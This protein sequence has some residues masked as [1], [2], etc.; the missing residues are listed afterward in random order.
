LA[1][2]SISVQFIFKKKHFIYIQN[3][4]KLLQTALFC[5]Q[6]TK[7]DI[8]TLSKKALMKLST[9][10]NPKRLLG[11]STLVLTLFAVG[12]ETQETLNPTLEV[13]QTLDGKPTTI[14]GKYIITLHEETLNYRKTND[15]DQ[16]QAGMR[17]VAQDIVAKYGVSST[18]VDRVYGSLLT[19]FSATLSPSQVAALRNDPSVQ[20]V[21]EDG[22]A[23]A[24]ADVKQTSATWGLDRIDQANLPLNTEY[25]YGQ[26]GEGVKVF[27]LDTGIL[28]GH[29]EFEG[30][31]Q[32]GYSGYDT[33]GTDRNG[34]GT[35]VAGTVGGKLYGVAKKA[36]LVSVKVLGDNGSGSLS[37]VIAGM[38]WVRANKG[39]SPAVVNMSL[40][41]GFSSLVNDAVKRL[42]DAGIPVIVAAGN[43]TADANNYSPSSAKEA[44]AVGASTTTDA[45][46]S[47]SNFGSAI[48]IFAPGSS[49][50]SAW[51]T[52]NTA[53]STISGT[54]MASPHV[55]GA[56]ALLLQTNP[57]AT[58]QQ[59]YDLI[60]T[61]ST[62]NKI[63][64]SSSIN[65]HLL[66]T[67]AG[68]V[69]NPDP[70]PQPVTI[71]L[72]GTVTKVSGRVRGNLT[73]SGFTS[74][75]SV[76]I[77]RNG[78][79]V[80]TTTNLTSYADQ[81]NIRGGGSITYRVCAENTTNCSATI[82]LTF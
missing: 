14:P 33:D 64:S 63:T 55:A 25:T 27:I 70:D 49:I 54:S 77:F 2:L 66:F 21:E 18:Q 36:T 31:A 3:T 52:S 17:K 12:C 19:G 8:Y 9:L 15:Y 51:W 22:I 34:H 7:K 10:F 82:T 6:R 61:N 4:K 75:Q 42:Y 50:T 59:I 80:A 46:A 24:Y 71:N 73:Y 11:I 35:H 13:V 41:S 43:S 62:K 79:R 53:L 67:R 30:R 69:V 58:A 28:Y 38:D 20:N 16:A 32:K 57:T 68:S 23:Y 72:S 76:Q 81:T 56:A 1:F 60:S 39:T 78:T 48:K 65:N 45:R 47:Y 44:Y 40:G 37:I 5:F 26:T 29:T 74:G